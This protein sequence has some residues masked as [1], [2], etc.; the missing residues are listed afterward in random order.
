MSLRD[1]FVRKL[2]NLGWAVCLKKLLQKWPIEIRDDLGKPLPLVA[3]PTYRKEEF[4][5]GWLKRKY[6]GP[7]AG[8]RLE[9]DSM[10]SSSAAYGALGGIS[11]FALLGISR[12]LFSGVNFTGKNALVMVV[13]GM[14]MWPFSP[15]ISRMVRA[16]RREAIR[17]GYLESSH[18]PS[19]DY[20]LPTLPTVSNGLTTCPECGGAWQLNP[21]VLTSNQVACISTSSSSTPPAPH[22][23]H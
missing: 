4:S 8:H 19:C 21:N 23:S 15:F 9:F 22:S 10:M 16:S 13:A 2:K 1:H 14:L 3:V 7:H 5:G 12:W 6:V 17:K 18:C 11:M 20:D